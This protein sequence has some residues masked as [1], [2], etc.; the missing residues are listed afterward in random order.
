MEVRLLF[1]KVGAE[2]VPVD[3]E[4]LSLTPLKRFFKTF[5]ASDN[6]S[7]ENDI[8]EERQWCKGTNL[9]YSSDQSP[10]R[11]GAF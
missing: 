3:A 10:H 8:V 1:D 2:E 7:Q 4:V 5:S 6:N 11:L 9:V